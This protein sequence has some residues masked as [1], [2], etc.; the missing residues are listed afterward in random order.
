M[1]GFFFQGCEGVSSACGHPTPSPTAFGVLHVL[2]LPSFLLS[3]S[4]ESEV[5][6]RRGFNPA[7][8]RPLGIPLLTRIAHWTAGRGKA[9]FLNGAGPPCDLTLADAPAVCGPAPVRGLECRDT[10]MAAGV[11]DGMP[12]C[13]HVSASA[14]RRTYP[15]SRHAP[16]MEN[17]T[18]AELSI[19]GVAAVITTDQALGLPVRRGRGRGSALRCIESACQKCLANFPLQPEGRPLAQGGNPVSAPQRTMNS[20]SRPLGRLSS[21]RTPERSERRERPGFA[22]MG[23]NERQAFARP[24]Q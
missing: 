10:G 6:N 8:S 19:P 21:F 1:A 23:K 15:T 24:S 17:L 22:S 11:G 4:S 13:V 2:S 7:S 16:A 12:Q 5:P 14:D 3:P 20:E 9:W 18:V